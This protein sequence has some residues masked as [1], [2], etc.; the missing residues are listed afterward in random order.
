MP[1]RMKMR[2]AAF[3]AATFAAALGAPAS[4]GAQSYP[5][6]PISI[7][8]PFPPGG[9]VDTLARILLDKMRAALGQTIII[10]NV[11]GASGGIGVTRVVRSAP[12]GYTLSMGNWTSHVG[13]PAIYPVQFDIL[14][15]LEPVAM[16]PSR[17]DHHRRAAEHAGEQPEGTGRLAEGQPGQGDRGDRRRRQPRPRQRPP[18]PEPDRHPH[19]V[20]ALSRRRPGEPGSGGGQVDLRIGAEASQMLPHVRAGRVKAYAVHGQDP[21]ARGARDSDHRR[22]RRAG[23]PH[24]GVDRAL[25]AQGHAE[26]YR[27]KAQRRDGRDPGRRGRAQAHRRDRLGNPAARATD[28]G[29]ARCLP[30]GRDRQVVADHQVGEHQGENRRGIARR[31]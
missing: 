17:A 8:V 12:D 6:R 26:R 2:T 23:R 16:L 4:A 29:S 3:L 30:Q 1:G 7:I 18:F 31:G 22:G 5:S 11:G 21:L 27:R 14:K 25:G 15:D 24:L 28:A 9:Q 19:A 13:G 10:E 20:R